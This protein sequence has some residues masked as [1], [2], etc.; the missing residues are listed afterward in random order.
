MN[1]VK[2]RNT[3][4][5]T[6]ATLTIALSSVAV[7]AVIAAVAV[8]WTVADAVYAVLSGDIEAEL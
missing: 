6:A 1:T 2:P 8:V 3:R 4:G 5:E 7:A